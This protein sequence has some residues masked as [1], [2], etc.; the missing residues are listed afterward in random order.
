MKKLILSLT[1]ALALTAACAAQNNGIQEPRLT[2]SQSTVAIW[3]AS[4]SRLWIDVHRPD[5]AKQIAVV[6]CVN[7]HTYF[8]SRDAEQF[9]PRGEY[10]SFVWRLD[11]L[12]P[13]PPTSI[14]VLVD[15]V[16]VKSVTWIPKWGDL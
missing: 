7:G 2:V 6:V 13:T 8:Q 10:E 5:G 4:V 9:S 11:A 1:I 16:P 12:S 3:G 14:V 15:G